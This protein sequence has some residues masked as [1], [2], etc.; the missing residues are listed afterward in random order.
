[1]INLEPKGQ[2]LM[3]I[4]RLVGACLVAVLAIGAAVASAAS[5]APEFKAAKFPVTFTGTSGLLVGNTWQGGTLHCASD[6]FTGVILGSHTFSGGRLVGLECVTILNSKECPQKTVGASGAGEIVTSTL[7]GE[8]GTVKT[9]EAASGVGLILEPETT[10]KL[11]LLAENECEL[12]TQVAGS[13]AGEVSPIGSS[14]TTGKLVFAVTGSKQDIRE[15]GLLGTV[16]KLGLNAFGFSLTQE[17]TE[18][19]EYA[20]AVEVS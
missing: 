19:L 15:I 17:S 12:E 8:L 11:Y 13:I 18:S 14:Q 7:K 1:M 6:H 16:K 4:A 20:S 5:A 10:K 2:R 9:S 3:K